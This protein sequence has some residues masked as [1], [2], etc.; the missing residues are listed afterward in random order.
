MIMFV[1]FY[2]L[3]VAS[4]LVGLLLLL[5]VTR[6]AGEHRSGNDNTTPTTETEHLR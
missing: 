4:A 2:L 6:P 3:G 5:D 1:M